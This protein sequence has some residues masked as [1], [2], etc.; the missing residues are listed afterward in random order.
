MLCGLAGAGGTE[1]RAGTKETKWLW[2]WAQTGQSLR[3]QVQTSCCPCHL[4]RHLCPQIGSLRGVQE[5]RG[6]LSEEPKPCGE[7]LS[8][9]GAAG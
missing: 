9:T 4:H 6:H 8:S 1:S 3:E 5:A 7:T 2:L